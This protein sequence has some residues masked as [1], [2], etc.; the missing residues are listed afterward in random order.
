MSGISVRS[1]FARFWWLG[2]IV[3]VACSALGVYLSARQAEEYSATSRVLVS[4]SEDLGSNVQGVR[5][6]LPSLAEQVAS[7]RNF[8]ATQEAL[9]EEL[10]DASW[11]VAVSIDDE[12]LVLTVTATSTDRD[13]VVPVANRFA[14]QIVQQQAAGER[15]VGEGLVVFSL[16]NP[17]G[18]ITSTAS[19]RRVLI[20]AGVAL[21][22]VLGALAMLSAQALRPSVVRAADLRRMGIAVIGEIPRH[23][24]T[25]GPRAVFADE[26]SDVADA[27]ERA[28]VG[29][30]AARVRA[31]RRALAA[32]SLAPGE[33]ASES[34]AGL[35][36]AIASMGHRVVAIGADLIDPRL[37]RQLG[38]PEGPGLAEGAD[39]RTVPGAPHSL[40]ALPA[41]RLTEHPLEAINSRLPQ[42]LTELEHAGATAIV[43]AP[44]L[45]SSA[46][47]VV[48]A[49]VAGASVLVV[50]AG[51]HSPAQIRQALTELESAGVLVLGVLL[52][53]VRVRRGAG[54]GRRRGAH[55]A[56]PGGDG[57]GDSGPVDVAEAR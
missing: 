56:P 1:A 9:P 10:Q 44:A 19:A 17:A 42:A 46:E 28:A 47:A 3:L 14:Q 32:L 31:G 53:G 7:R 25:R 57:A 34:A 21:G 26:R 15:P 29:L 2:L 40:G 35:S 22:L 33:G 23:D 27:Y 52:T 30:E 43:D 36:W 12:A 20:V 48:V 49:S 37:H 4:P 41:G 38:V 16:L 45:T 55:Q 51:A 54:E 24:A 13:V 18:S 39:P 5:F 8:E 11:D 6:V 50:R